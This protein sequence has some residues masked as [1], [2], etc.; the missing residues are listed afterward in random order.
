[1]H[2]KETPVRDEHDGINNLGDFPVYMRPFQSLDGES[3]LDGASGRYWAGRIKEQ[4]PILRRTLKQI[5]SS[6]TMK[7]PGG[8]RE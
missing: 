7:S 3:A 8:K 1:M 4:V 2:A 5:I 6:V